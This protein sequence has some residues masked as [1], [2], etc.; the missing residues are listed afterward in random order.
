MQTWE[1]PEALGL[2]LKWCLLTKTGSPAPQEILVS[3]HCG[4]PCSPRE[5]L[6][7]SRTSYLQR[8]RPNRKYLIQIAASHLTQLVLCKMISDH[9]Q[10]TPFLATHG[11]QESCG[12]WE[13]LKMS[14]GKQRRWGFRSALLPGC[15]SWGVGSQAVPPPPPPPSLEDGLSVPG[16]QVLICEMW[17]SCTFLLGFLCDYTR[18]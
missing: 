6:P 2:L 3:P 5:P 18:L 8:F 13:I 4:D 16:L 1:N 14:R 12:H 10:P 15:C 7:S 17:E 9:S 11:L